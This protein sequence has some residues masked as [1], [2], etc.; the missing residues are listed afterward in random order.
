MPTRGNQQDFDNENFVPYEDDVQESVL[1]PEADIVDAS[2]KPVNQQSVTHLLINVE[3]LLSHGE[4]Q[5]IE[6]SVRQAVLS[7]GKLIGSFDKNPVQ[8]SLLYEVEF[9]DGAVKQYSANMISENILMNVDSSGYHNH[10]HARIL[11]SKKD[12]TSLTKDNALLTTKQGNW[13]LCKTTMGWQ[14]HVK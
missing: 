12:V 5:Q 6:K 1:T 3:L 13:K 7:G 8:N 9:P 11:D 10:I 14:F 4:D 2:G